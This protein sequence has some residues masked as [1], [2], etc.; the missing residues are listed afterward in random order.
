MAQDEIGPRVRRTR[1]QLRQALTQLLLE[2][3]LRSIT[4]RELTDGR[5]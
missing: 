4:V 5:M 3:E 2:K 1:A